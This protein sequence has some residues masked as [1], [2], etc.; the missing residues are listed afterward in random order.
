MAFLN[1]FTSQCSRDTGF[2]FQS[3]LEISADFLFLKYLGRLSVNLVRL[4]LIGDG[5]VGQITG[6]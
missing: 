6:E 4:G 1:L 2:S 3:A 5:A